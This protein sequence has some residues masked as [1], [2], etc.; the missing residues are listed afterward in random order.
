[1]HAVVVRI[2]EVRVIILVAGV[3]VWDGLPTTL[4]GGREVVLDQLYSAQSQKCGV[5]S[6]QEIDPGE[7]TVHK[8]E[9]FD[10]LKSLEEGIQT[11]AEA[12]IDTK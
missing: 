11:V 7:S 10:V 8:H 1:M 4:A 3:R 9:F 12:T 6:E 2:D 5:T